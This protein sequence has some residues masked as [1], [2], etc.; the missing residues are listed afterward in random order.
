[1]KE[2]PSDEALRHAYRP[3]ARAHDRQREELMAAISNVDVTRKDIGARR[4]HRRFAGIGLSLAAVLLVG[5]TLAV[6]LWQTGASSA[7]A[8]E[9]ARERLM[10]VRSLYLKGWKYRTVE[11]DGALKVERFPLEFYAER[12]SRFWSN[13]HSFFYDRKQKLTNVAHQ[14]T[15][16]DGERSIY[17]SHSERLAVIRPT[18]QL[19]AQLLTEQTLQ[20]R[21]FD[22]LLVGLPEAYRHVGTENVQGVACNVYECHQASKVGF[23]DRCRLWL[24]RRSGMPVRMKAWTTFD[25]RPEELDYEYHTIRINGPPREGMFS[26]KAPEDYQVN[27]IKGEAKPLSLPEGPSSSGGG[28]S[29]YRWIPFNIDDRAV[30]YCWRIS[31]QFKQENLLQPMPEL[32]L[33]RPGEERPCRHV[34]LRFDPKWNWSLFLPQREGDRLDLDDQLAVVFKA[35]GVVDQSGGRPLRL[36]PEQLELILAEVQRSSIPPDSGIEPITLQRIRAAIDKPIP[37]FRSQVDAAK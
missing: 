9:Q 6:A 8:V 2:F 16:S 14:Y 19:E 31:S 35:K 34:L 7:A 5:V 21:I 33:G 13:G 23:R 1:M 22:R 24:D 25:D 12:P 18:S 11:R 32:L 20:G 30:L 3:F 36:P 4:E 10:G 28:L 37:L 17:V 15:A 27:V 26:F 29:F